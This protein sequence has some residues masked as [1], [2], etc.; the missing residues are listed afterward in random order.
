MPEP[1]RKRHHNGEVNISTFN[2][3]NVKSAEVVDEA[4][5]KMDSRLIADYMVQ[6]TKRFSEQSSLDDFEDIR[7]PGNVDR[8]C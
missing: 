7:I 5:G 1:S 4:V 6:R 3:R 8:P 2:K